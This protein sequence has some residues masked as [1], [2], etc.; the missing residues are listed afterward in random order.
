M[1]LAQVTVVGQE[2]AQRGERLAGQQAGQQAHQTPGQRRLVQ[3]RLQRNA[4][5]AEHCTVGLPEKA[6]RQ[7]D[8][9]RC[10]DAAAV[11]AGQ[12]QLQPLGDAVALHQHQLVL[13]RRQRMAVHPRHR[14]LAQLLQAVAVHHHES[15]RQ[16]VVLHVTLHSPTERALCQLGATKSVAA[17]GLLPGTSRPTDQLSESLLAARIDA[18]RCGLQL[19]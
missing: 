5:A 16:L 7:L 11:L 12:R 10:G 18:T 9:E 2:A 6:R 1:A 3:R 4:V 15:G 19:R 13:Q 8:L 14:Q 17:G